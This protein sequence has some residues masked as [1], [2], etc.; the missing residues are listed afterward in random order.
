MLTVVVYR[1]KL[2]VFLHLRADT[3]S[4][5]MNDFIELFILIVYSCMYSNSLV[6]LFQKIYIYIRLYVL[7]V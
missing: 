6:Q 5:A 7:F 3:H 2:A 4:K 1:I